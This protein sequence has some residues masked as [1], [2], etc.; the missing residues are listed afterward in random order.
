MRLS[1]RIYK[2]AELVN[3]GS[4]VA[5]IGTDH[6]Y[7]PMLLLK[8]GK[9][10][11]VI[12]SDI[13]QDSLSKA[14]DTFMQTGLIYKTREED[15]RV[16][17]GL[18][19]IDPGEVDEV[20]I[21]GLGGHTIAG[22]LALDE[23]KARSFKRLIL[24]PRK[25]SGSLRYYLCTHGWEIESENLA[26]E[27]KFACEI[28]TA[29]PKDAD[30]LNNIDQQELLPED[31]IRWKYPAEM[32]GSDPALAR[33]RIEWKIDSIKTELINLDRANIADGIVKNERSLLK[34]RLKEDLEYLESLISS[35][36]IRDDQ[37][38]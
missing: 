10:P 16:G 4:I 18:S 13:S 17:D 38:L 1:K 25:H 23:G 19:V 28:I 20:I 27:G 14:R 24:Q 33:M 2:L 15:F 29:V 8:E 37:T 3:D 35:L 36:R 21:A 26:P 22:I 7:V 31:D 6:G 34:E 30:G 9:T 11:G 5:D 32:A 12:M